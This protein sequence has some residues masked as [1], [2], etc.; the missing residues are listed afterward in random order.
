MEMLTL[1]LNPHLVM[2]AW[3]VRPLEG[4][5]ESMKRW[6]AEAIEDDEFWRK[7]G[8]GFGFGLVE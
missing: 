5:S 6:S 7:I 3:T 2:W 1:G 8:Q 4:E